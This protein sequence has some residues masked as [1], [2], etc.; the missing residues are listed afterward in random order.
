MPRMKNGVPA[1]LGR[2]T[3]LP[4]TNTAPLIEPFPSWDFNKL[5]DCDALQNV[6]NVEIDPKGIM[7]IL[8]GGHAHSL[9]EKPVKNCS[10]QLVMYDVNKNVTLSTYVFPD[11]VVSRTASFLYDLVI[12]GEFV[13]ITD[14]V[15]TDPGIV[16][17]SKRANKSWKIRH[18]TMYGDPKAQQFKIND[19]VVDVK[20]NIAGLALGPKSQRKSSELVLNQDREVFYTPISS[21]H[22]Y[23]ISTGVLQN[24]SNFNNGLNFSGDVRDVGLKASQT[25]GIMMT[26]RGVLYYGLLGSNSIA[27][28]NS[29]K[30]FQSSQVVLSKDASY[31]QWTNS[32]TIDT[33]GTITV[34]SSTLQKLIRGALD[35]NRYNFWL[36]SAEIGEKSYLYDDLTFEY[37]R[38]SSSEPSTKLTTPS[39]TAATKPT[40][41]QINESVHETGHKGS[42]NQK[43]LEV[44]LILLSIKDLPPQPLEIAQGYFYQNPWVEIRW[45]REEIAVTLKLLVQKVSCKQFMYVSIGTI[46]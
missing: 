37:E 1:T 40:K 12:D 34:L 20:I 17:Y 45:P 8:D 6:Q 38:E 9:T 5:D 16:V 30:S 41:A 33:N 35:V 3:A 24:E 27:Q 7:Y 36:L 14:H 13:Y 25:D 28:W 46:A 10:A 22:L 43:I 42:G 39:S 21:L 23:S 19:E 11:H 15:A 26:N 32:F 2:I 29:S 44:S 31:I 4:K 18:P